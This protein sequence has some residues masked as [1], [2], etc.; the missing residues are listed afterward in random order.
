[1]E[2]SEYQLQA[3]YGIPMTSTASEHAHQRPSPKT[4][5]WSTISSGRYSIG[6]QATD[7]CHITFYSR[8]ITVRHIPPCD[9][10]FQ[11][12][13]FL[14]FRSDYS[15]V[16]FE[17]DKDITLQFL[18]VRCSVPLVSRSV[19]EFVSVRSGEVIE[20]SRATRA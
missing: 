15:S 17:F 9:D 2:A 7:S 4:T 6:P 13:D 5:C 1:M 18:M 12:D 3:K 14:H 10:S 19:A 20:H 11:N 16:Q 8:K